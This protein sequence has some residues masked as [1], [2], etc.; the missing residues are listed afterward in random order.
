MT[1]KT[2]PYKDSKELIS[3]LRTL[4]SAVE[5]MMPTIDSESLLRVL[6]DEIFALCESVDGDVVIPEKPFPAPEDSSLWKCGWLDCFHGMGLAGRGM[7][8]GQWWNE[9]CSEYKREEDML[10]EWKKRSDHDE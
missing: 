5:R 3:C 1:T 8:P 4:S 6:L 2:V 10:E 7:C 9:S